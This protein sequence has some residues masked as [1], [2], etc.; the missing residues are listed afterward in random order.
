VF[1]ATNKRDQIIGIIIFSSLINEDI[2]FRNLDSVYGS[3]KL[4]LNSDIGNL[5]RQNNFWANDYSSVF[6][7]TSNSS[8]SLRLSI[9][10]KK[11][12]LDDSSP[13]I[14]KR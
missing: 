6:L 11:V 4:I 13:F 7:T 2:I 3:Q 14:S 1:I 10:R 8:K 9:E 12:S 5:K